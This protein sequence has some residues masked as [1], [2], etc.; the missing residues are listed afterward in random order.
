MEDLIE[1]LNSGFSLAI[2]GFRSAVLM[3][4]TIEYSPILEMCSRV[5]RLG[6]STARRVRLY[7]EEFEIVSEPFPDANGIAVRAKSRKDPE[8]RVVHLPVMVIQT[9]NVQPLAKAA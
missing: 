9:A 3:T 8:I 1:P 4:R 6:Y 7:G 2:H 5:K